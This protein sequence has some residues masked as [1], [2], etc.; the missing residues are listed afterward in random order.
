MGCAART[1]RGAAKRP[2]TTAA[3]R[4]HQRPRER[5]RHVR[6][7]R[8]SAAQNPAVDY[9]RHSNTFAIG[10]DLPALDEH[11]GWP[12]ANYSVGTC[13]IP[14]N[15]ATR[16]GQPGY[17]QPGNWYE[18]YSFARRTPVGGNFGFAD[19]SVR[20]VS[21]TINLQAYRDLAT[22]RGKDVPS[23]IP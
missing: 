13:A 17:Q 8:Q 19:G 15:N 5:Q 14:L 1:G 4:R 10:E 9:R 20:F 6:P 3:G 23:E 18:T 22:I 11:C 16:P 2:G 7:H 12:I 21:E